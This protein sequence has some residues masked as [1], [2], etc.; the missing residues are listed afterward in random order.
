MDT[1]RALDRDSVS[2]DNQ[3]HLAAIA[4]FARNL[5]QATLTRDVGSEF[6]LGAERVVPILRQ[7]LDGEREFEALSQ[8]REELPKVRD[9]LRQIVGDLDR[10]YAR[11][12][13]QDKA[14]DRK[15]WLLV[16]IH[17]EGALLALFPERW[18]AMQVGPGV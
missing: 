6:L 14:I 17:M 13:P 4:S 1:H 12:A 16:G 3:Q 15:E 8:L 18:N 11:R 10:S 2:V 5:S 7:Y 9:A